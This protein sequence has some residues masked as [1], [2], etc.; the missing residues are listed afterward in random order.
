MVRRLARHFAR[1]VNHLSAVLRFRLSGS[2]LSPV[3][4][5]ILTRPRSGS[6]NLKSLLNSLP[7]SLND[8]EIL[9]YSVLF[10]FSH[11]LAKCGNSGFR[12]YGCKVM[13]YQIKGRQRMIGKESFIRRLHEK[14]FK[15]IYLNRENVVHQAVSSIRAKRFGFS[16]KTMYEK[17]TRDKAIRE[18]VTVDVSQL[19]RHLHRSK[20][21]ASYEELLL[22]GVPHLSLSYEEDL[23]RAED[24]QPTMDRVCDYLGIERGNVKTSFKK[25]SPEKL[26]DSVANY[27]ELASAV[28]DTPFAKYLD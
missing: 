26:R 8:G 21:F 27:D 13:S 19:L 15:I 28:K 20:A 16:S 1:N 10:P 17:T 6:T 24:H 4:Y 3:R 22:E 7:N 18:K 23:L 14:G 9:R 11:V 5:V 25:V 12:A 2:K